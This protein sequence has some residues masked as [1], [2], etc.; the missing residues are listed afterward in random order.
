[1]LS[2]L[3]YC[4]AIVVSANVAVADSSLQLQQSCKIRRDIADT[5][6]EPDG[7][8]YV[9]DSARREILK[10]DSSGNLLWSKPISGPSYAMFGMVAASASTSWNVLA[11]SNGKPLMD[12]SSDGTITDLFPQKPFFTAGRI[13]A[14]ATG[15]LFVPNDRKDRVEIYAPKSASGGSN[16]KY[17]DT[18][19]LIKAGDELVT[20][21]K[22]IDGSAPGPSRLKSPHSVFVDYFSGRTW[23]LDTTY[24][25]MV[26]DK[27]CKFLFSVKASDPRNRSFTY[28]TG[29]EFDAQGNTYIGSAEMHGILKY[30]GNGRLVSKTKLVTGWPIGFG[31]GPDGSYYVAV[32]NGDLQPDGRLSPAEIKVFSQVGKPLKTITIPEP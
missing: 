9:L 8:L 1:M 11:L 26:F 3:L 32:N 16:V 30:D 13:A 14:D 4:L 15:T 29:M 19:D 23:V 5:L 24:R 12:I 21:T 7:T 2:K 20:C 10:L 17:P 27:S 25:L 31:L 6:V 18:P 22:V 28:I